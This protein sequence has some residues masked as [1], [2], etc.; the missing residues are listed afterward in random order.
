M[1]QGGKLS[2]FQL[3]EASMMTREQEPEQEKMNRRPMLV[4]HI[5]VVTMIWQLPL[6]TLVCIGDLTI[7]GFFLR[8]SLLS[9]PISLML[10]ALLFYKSR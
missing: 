7:P 10:V 2:P 4:M 1:V 6:P 5:I 8:W 3:L 9:L